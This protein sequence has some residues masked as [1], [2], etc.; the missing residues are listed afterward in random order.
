M[1]KRN[2]ERNEER[3]ET[4]KHVSSIDT[5]VADAM[6]LL[7]SFGSFCRGNEGSMFLPL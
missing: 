6:N 7:D 4:V 3:N 1:E 2:E 5:F